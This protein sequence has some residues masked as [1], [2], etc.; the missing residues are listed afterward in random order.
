ML[1]LG[2][3]TQKKKNIWAF[4]DPFL[5]WEQGNWKILENWILLWSTCSKIC[6]MYLCVFLAH[7]YVFNPIIIFNNIP[8]GC[9]IIFLIFNAM[10]KYI[11]V[12]Y[13]IVC[14]KAFI[15]FIPVYYKTIFVNSQHEKTNSKG[16]FYSIS[17]FKRS[18]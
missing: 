13:P 18:F 8:T 15:H 14:K 11:N 5:V 4:S 9:T 10:V 2:Y 16:D 17:S 1:F 12:E 7:L 6:N 3:I